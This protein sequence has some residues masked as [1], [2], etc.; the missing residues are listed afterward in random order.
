MD[1]SIFDFIWVLWGF[2][3]G[4][5]TCTGS[6]KVLPTSPFF[7]WNREVY[8]ISDRNRTNTL[9][10][11]VPIGRNILTNKNNLLNAVPIGRKILTNKTILL[12]AVPIGRKIL[13][14]KNT[15][16]NA[17]PIGHKISTKKHPF[18]CRANR[19]WNPYEENTLCLEN[20]HGTFS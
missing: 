6:T 15:L 12:N 16:L 7:D 18:K 2:W 1:K 14:N 11:A 19:T 3:V 8:T 4:Q 9:L 20:I 5:N 10:N 13:T 17:V